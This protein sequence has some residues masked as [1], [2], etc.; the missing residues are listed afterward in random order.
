MNRRTVGTKNPGCCR[1]VAIIEMWCL[2]YFTACTMYKQIGK[3][4]I[5]SSWFNVENLQGTGSL[6]SSYTGVK[7]YSWPR[8]RITLLQEKWWIGGCLPWKLWTSERKQEWTGQDAVQG[9]KQ[10]DWPTYNF[11]L[12]YP[13]IVK[14]TGDENKEIHQLGDIVLT[15]QRIRCKT[16]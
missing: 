1:V 6:M 4:G 2:W 7:N 14:Q 13:Y 12:Q 3:M 10:R 8:R 11:S 15:P 5:N 16:N 9:E